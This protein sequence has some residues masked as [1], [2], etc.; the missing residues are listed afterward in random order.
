MAEKEFEGDDPMEFVA[1]RFPAPP[2]V[3]M[4]E[5]MARCFIEEYALMG[6]PRKRI[7]AMFRSPAFAGAHAV[8]AARGEEFIVGLVEQVFGPARRAEV[9]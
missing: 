3:D 4:D 8:F 6:M 2:G 9:A 5:A 7:L 1:M